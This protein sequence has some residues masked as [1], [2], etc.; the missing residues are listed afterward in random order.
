MKKKSKILNKLITA[1]LAVL[2]VTLL[3]VPAFASDETVILPETTFVYDESLDG[4]FLDY[5]LPFVV[6]QEYKVVWNNVTYS[7]ICSVADLDGN[8]LTGLI[9][10]FENPEFP[11]AIGI[12]DGITAFEPMLESAL[13]PD[14]GSFTVAIYGISSGSSEPVVNVSGTFTPSAN[15]DRTDMKAVSVPLVSG[16]KYLV[17]INGD[18]Y[19]VTA[20]SFFYEGHEWFGLG[21]VTYF[22]FPDNALADKS[23]PFAF[24]TSAFGE[25]FFYVSSQYKGEVSYSIVSFEEPFVPSLFDTAGSVVTSLTSWIG[26]VA[27]MV[28]NEPVLLIG[29][30][31]G[32]ATLAF[33]IF[34]SLKR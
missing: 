3:C 14:D 10:D 26:N 9:P 16:Q 23:V 34:K 22:P 20:F 19:I 4:F 31:I 21:D 13:N 15:N 7:I 6:G 25:S 11:F 5:E 18:E 30:T 32:L 28:I 33:G 29:F 12:F 27:R 24:F 1:M 8:V 2:C 17:T